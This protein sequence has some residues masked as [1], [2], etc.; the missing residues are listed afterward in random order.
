MHK[1]LKHALG[2]LALLISC[3][4]AA[5]ATDVGLNFEDELEARFSWSPLRPAVGEPVRFTDLSTGSPVLWWWELGDGT[6]IREQHP[7]HV[8]TSS[9]P[10]SVMLMVERE[11]GPG[12]TTYRTVTV[13]EPPISQLHRHAYLVPAS[14]RAPGAA[15]TSWV[16]DLVLHNHSDSEALVALFLLEKDNDNSSV[17]AIS[18]PLAAGFSRRLA[19][20]VGQLFGADS[21]SGAILVSSTVPLLITSRTYNDAASGTYGQLIPGVDVTATEPEPTLI[22]LTGNAG[23]RTN[24]GCANPS[25]LASALQIELYRSDSTLIDTLFQ[26][27]PAYGFVQLNHVFGEVGVAD[28]FAKVWAEP[29]DA[30]HLY[31][32]V[33]DN[34]SGDP[35][36][37]RPLPFTDEPLLIPAAAHIAGAAGTS[38]RTDLEIANRGAST[39]DVRIEALD[40]K[41]PSQR[42]TATVSIPASHSRRYLDALDSLLGI[43]GAT[44][45]RLIPV[46][47][48]VTATSRT[49]NDQPS[50]TYGQLIPAFAESEA[51]LAGEEARLLQ[52]SS[53]PLAKT[54]DDWWRMVS[55]GTD[56]VLLDVAWTG[57]IWVA[58]GRGG[59]LLTSTDGAAW[60]PRTSTSAVELHAIATGGPRLIVVGDKGTILR[61]DDGRTWQHASSRVNHYIR[62]VVWNGSEYLAVGSHSVILSSS[63]GTYWSDRSPALEPTHCHHFESVTWSNGQYV[64]LLKGTC[65]Y[66]SAV[67]TSEDGRSWQHHDPEIPE[68]GHLWGITSAG[69]AYLAFGSYT[70]ENSSTRGLVATSHDGATWSY[71]VLD[72]FGTLVTGTWTGSQAYAIGNN[73]NIWTS[74]DLVTWE[75][76]QIVDHHT[77][78]RGIAFNGEQTVAVGSAGAILVNDLPVTHSYRTNIGLVNIGDNQIEVE[79][80]LHRGNGS[81]LGQ[82]T[83][84]VPAWSHHQENGIIAQVTDQP[85]DN[86]HAVVVSQTPGALYLAYASVVDN[87]SGDPIFIPALS[88]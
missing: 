43:D 62:D 20:V 47:G 83:V 32:S 16:S 21:T 77:D 65:D 51:L 84:Q 27:V 69:D 63:N 7:T 61:S 26:T 72:R 55:S 66:P 10:R 9:G 35:I 54:G 24:I 23:Y 56:V 60:V 50:G 14:A 57:S 88:R 11:T 13:V 82:R 78:L 28:G 41:S 31:A 3:I 4:A 81:L 48:S 70:P 58:V 17:R 85:V 2:T 18:L 75:L 6:V 73:T 46:A 44:A 12:V 76:V 49:F 5:G 87:R 37:I 64:A 33:V 45:L 19:D 53:L 68:G 1:A 40:G 86:A 80:R 39:A 42:P 79:L 15:G 22:Q 71:T 8:Y 59:T 30:V 52:L 34:R 25:D 74:T 67:L 38:W 29:D 36:F